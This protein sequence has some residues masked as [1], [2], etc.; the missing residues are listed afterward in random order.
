MTRKI[1]PNIEEKLNPC[2]KNDMRNLV[3][4]NASSG[5]SENLTFDG[6]LL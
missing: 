3:E 1:Y 5:N 4:F 6:L 2:L